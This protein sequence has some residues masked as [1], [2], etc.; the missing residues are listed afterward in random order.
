MLA[1]YSLPTVKRSHEYD[2]DTSKHIDIRTLSRGESGP[3]G[4]ANF[5]PGHGDGP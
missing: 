1:A 2:H 3:M 4:H 5:R